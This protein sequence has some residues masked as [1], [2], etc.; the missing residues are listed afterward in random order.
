MKVILNIEVGKE[1]SI[2][3]LNCLMSDK[4]EIQ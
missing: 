1:N 2:V 3:K 4:A